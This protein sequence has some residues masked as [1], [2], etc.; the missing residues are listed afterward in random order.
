MIV[1]LNKRKIPSLIN[2]LYNFQLA[3]AISHI[4][5]CLKSVSVHSTN[6]SW[7]SNYC[8]AY[9][10]WHYPASYNL[11]PPIKYSYICDRVCEYL[12]KQGE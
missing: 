12:K 5:I 9:M 11:I 2:K 1:Y 7:N 4:E 10:R 3:K 8:A 6:L